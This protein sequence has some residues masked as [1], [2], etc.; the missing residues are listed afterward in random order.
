MAMK[1]RIDD[2]VVY[3]TCMSCATQ[4][5]LRVGDAPKKLKCPNC[6]SIMIAVLKSYERENAKLLGKDKLTPHEKKDLQRMSKN[7]NLVMGDGKRAVFALAGRGIGPDSAARLLRGI[8]V[9][10]DDFLRGIMAAEVQYA[11]TKRFWD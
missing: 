3:G 4:R 9:D 7:A 2:E 1:K 5:R 10:E 11:K 8:F 6:G